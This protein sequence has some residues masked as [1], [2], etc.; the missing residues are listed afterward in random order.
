MKTIK[1]LTTAF[2]LGSTAQALAFDSN[3]AIDYEPLALSLSCQSGFTT[4]PSGYKFGGVDR[5]YGYY[6]AYY[7]RN[8]GLGTRIHYVKSKFTGQY[9][10]HDP[11]EG[12]WEN[13]LTAFFEEFGFDEGVEVRG[14][15][16][17]TL[18]ACYPI[19][20]DPIVSPPAQED[21]IFSFDN[22]VMTA[23]P[24][25]KT[26]GGVLGGST[27]RTGTI[28]F[29][30]TVNYSSGESKYYLKSFNG[31]YSEI[32]M[33]DNG[34]GS[35]SFPQYT[36][37]DVDSYG[38][39]NEDSVQAC[40]TP[41][42]APVEPTPEP[43]Y[44]TVPGD[45]NYSPISSIDYREFC[46]AGFTVGGASGASTMRVGT[47]TV[48]HSYE[49]AN[50]T[51]S[52]SMRQNA[53]G[54]YDTFYTAQ[55]AVGIIP[56]PTAT[57]ALVDKYGYMLPGSE[58][59]CLPVVTAP[60]VPTYSF[61]LPYN[62]YCKA[63]ETVGGATGG[64]NVR[65]G[66]VPVY[67]L[68][69]PK[70][71]T[72][73]NYFF[74]GVNYTPITM[75]EQDGF[76]MFPQITE[77]M[78]KKYGALDTNSIAACQTVSVELP[79]PTPPQEGWIEFGYE[80]CAAGSTVGGVEG[81]STQRIGTVSVW[82]GFDSYGTQ[83]Y[84]FHSAKT[85]DLVPFDF[86]DFES[87]V[88]PDWDIGKGN[89][90]QYGTWESDSVQAC[91]PVRTSVDAVETKTENC[92]APLTGTITLQR[93]YKLWS[94][95]VKDQYGDWS[96]TNNACVVP[97]VV[98]DPTPPVTVPTDPAE[99][100]DDFVT[101]HEFELSR[102]VCEE[103]QTGE[104][105]YR[106]DW[107][108]D[109]YADGRKENYTAKTK[110]AL[111][112]TCK[113]LTDDLIETKPRE[114]SESCPNGQVGTIIILG[115]DVTYSLSGTKFVE[116]S[117][118]NNCVA[119]L[120][121]FE[122]E[123]K[124][125]NCSAGQSGSIKSVRYAATKTDGTKVY[126]YGETYSVVENTCSSPSEADVS[127]EIANGA[128]RGILANQSVK[129]SDSAQVKVITDYV[130]N[131]AADFGDYKLNISVDSIAVDSQKLG[132][133]THAWVS[134]TGGKI[135]LGSLPRSPVSYIGKGGITKDNASK[136]VIRDV[137]FSQSTGKLTVHYTQSKSILDTGS[138]QRFEVPLIDAG[139]AGSAL[140]SVRAY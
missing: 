99:P 66:K 26:V 29:Y 98:V 10:V 21:P 74:D 133:L 14:M 55:S 6:P 52:W 53:T 114:I 51:S 50:Q 115:Q 117:R 108:Y 120:S 32:A 131:A 81:G 67:Y 119:E 7:D 127:N 110:T 102:E 37:A 33:T 54:S 4:D 62:E 138:V 18:A 64:S 97:P 48:Y 82:Y 58:A 96:V 5:G 83:Q 118:Q 130:N 63:G 86:S 22:M 23:C 126:P 36:A 2:L 80:N 104:K 113:T 103:G 57:Q 11:L 16:T 140:N 41:P 139:Q 137:S 35:F 28:P 34:D 45:K 95:G 91:T 70:T 42:T 13:D 19:K 106:F 94:D 3:S 61:D 112:N 87:Y 73:K 43:T 132:A 109:L 84:Y 105:T 79:E 129:A 128:A 111:T 78:V 47:I 60:A 8:Q 40:A 76:S 31:L 101:I 24:Y 121:D 46:P 107:T 125:E 38:K 72:S 124:T 25:G 75:T 134:K 89:I 116:I 69:D 122:S 85:G 17:P 56:Y 100:A 90:D 123:F 88:E 1:I 44:P 20:D 15:I 9:L 30:S 59:A 39:W 49:A 135:N 93:S 77:E 92:T 27:Y 71:F 68:F 65:T 12:A 136:T